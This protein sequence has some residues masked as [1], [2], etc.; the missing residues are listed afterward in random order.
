MTAVIVRDR[1]GVAKALEILDFKA[2]KKV[3]VKPNLMGPH[4]GNSGMVT[5]PKVMDQLLTWLL[6]RGVDV[7]VGESTSYRRDTLKAL[8]ISGVGKILRKYGVDFVDLKK[9]P[10][11]KKYGIEIAKIATKRKIINVPVLK[12]HAQTLMTIGCKNLKGIISDEEKRRFHRK[13]LH[14]MIAKIALKIKP[15]LTLVDAIYGIDGL[16]PSS[17][18]RR[19]RI[20]YLVAGDNNFDV[21]CTCCELVGLNWKKV[22]YL[23]LM[24]EK[25]G[26]PKIP[27]I[28]KKVKF[29][30]PPQD[31]CHRVLGVSIYFGE[32]CSGC[33]GAIARAGNRLLRKHFLR[34][35]FF[36]CDVYAG[37]GQNIPVGAIAVGSCTG[38]R[39][40]VKGCPPDEDEILKI[41]EKKLLNKR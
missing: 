39:C 9:E 28:K 40:D 34:L 37:K 38:T 8:R 22:G 29:K 3:L 18:G 13:G 36:R 35:P 1:E 11:V 10:I 41:L 30:L 26:K 20:G 16:G 14:E 6:E 31:K 33:T 17:L 24:S 25:L 27:E 23:K 12:T 2:P 4:R 15:V 21:D 7:V 32:A 19:R 5:S